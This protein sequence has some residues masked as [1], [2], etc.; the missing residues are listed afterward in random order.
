MRTDSGLRLDRVEKRTAMIPK[1]I[2][3]CWFGGSPLPPLAEKCIESWRKY[4]PDY[5][6]KEWNE[7]NYDF[8]KNNYMNQAYEAKKWGFVPDYA[9]IDILHTYGGVYLDTDV[10]MIKPIDD[11]MTN[12]AFCG[13]E[14][15]QNVAF[16]LG[17]GSVAGFSL[18]K[19]LLVEYDKI[20]FINEDRS[21]NL[22]ASPVYTTK[23][24]LER[25]LVLNGKLQATDG[26]TVYPTEYFCPLNYSTGRLKITQ[27]AYTIH[28]YDASWQT[29]EDKARAKRRALFCR[30]FGIKLGRKLESYFHIVKTSSLSELWCRV[31]NRFTKN[32]K[33]TKGTDQDECVL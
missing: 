32:D 8:T 11:I 19:D 17:F 2:H 6:I 16:G 21:L 20:S 5:E 9:R 27:K 30:L 31:K 24:L 18:W 4:C 12:S 25:G 29:G 10:E 23:W 26:L 1:V 33:R 14:D 22:T 7:S 28:H 15:K 13:F 3:Y